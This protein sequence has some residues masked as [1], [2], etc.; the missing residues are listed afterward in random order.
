MS[1][2]PDNRLWGV[3]GK[4]QTYYSPQ[5]FLKGKTKV[6]LN[7]NPFD[8]WDMKRSKFYRV[9]GYDAA[10]QG[11]AVPQTTSTPVVSPSP[12]PSFT[13]TQTQTNTP[14]NTQTNTPTPSITPTLT[15]SPTPP[16][17]WNTNN[18]N[19]ENENQNWNN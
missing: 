16:I 2:K 13:P 7:A 1:K 8:S 4:Q 3:L 18:T 17:K 10:Q 9:D 14:T 5:Q 11:G 6:P 15:P 12:T 19:W